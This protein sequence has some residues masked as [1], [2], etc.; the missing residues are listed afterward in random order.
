MQETKCETNEKKL[1]KK[2]S[3]HFS[4][5]EEWKIKMSTETQAKILLKKQ[6]TRILFVTININRYL[7]IRIILTKIPFQDN[8]SFLIPL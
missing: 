5:V 7:V 3:L 2:I 1:A 4:K 8:S 6:K